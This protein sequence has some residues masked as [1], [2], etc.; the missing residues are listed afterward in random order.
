[1]VSLPLIGGDEGVNNTSQVPIPNGGI[2]T[3]WQKSV[4]LYFV[5]LYGAQ[6]LKIVLQ[7]CEY[8]KRDN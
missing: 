2:S 5:V 7:L 6:K 1:M 8:I 3:G 4:R